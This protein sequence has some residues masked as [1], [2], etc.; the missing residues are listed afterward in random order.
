MNLTHSS[1]ICNFITNRIP[2]KHSSKMT[3]TYI[4]VLTLVALLTA[5]PGDR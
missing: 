1:Y 5:T 4:F 3:S 2:Y